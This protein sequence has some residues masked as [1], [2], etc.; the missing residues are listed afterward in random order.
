L[1][2]NAYYIQPHMVNSLSVSSEGNLSSMENKK[3]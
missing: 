2:I 1:Y 3:S